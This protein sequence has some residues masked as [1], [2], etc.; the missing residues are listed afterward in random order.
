MVEPLLA[1]SG[2]HRAETFRHGVARILLDY[3]LTWVLPELKKMNSFERSHTIVCT[4]SNHE[5][6]FDCLASF[7]ISG[8]VNMIN[9]N[10]V[11]GGI[12][13]AAAAQRFYHYQSGLTYME[14]RVT[15]LLLLGSCTV[16]TAEQL[17]I[18][19]KTVN[20]HI[21]NILLKF[22]YESRAQYIA[23]LLGDS[24]NGNRPPEP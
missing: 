24:R 11:I 7:H 22:G 20:A 16:R 12:H 5:A 17:R 21:S 18:T 8:V 10:G 6:Y 14:M 23:I 9:E 15:R 13:S 1:R 19:P 4:Q 2:I 3:P